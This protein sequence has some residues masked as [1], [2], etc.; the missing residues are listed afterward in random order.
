MSRSFQETLTLNGENDN[1][2]DDVDV[3]WETSSVFAVNS[4]G[5]V[6]SFKFDSFNQPPTQ[7]R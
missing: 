7:E 6:Y 2:I 5:S 3:D 1:H 4:S